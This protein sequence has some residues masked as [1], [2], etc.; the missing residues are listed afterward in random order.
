MSSGN[1]LKIAVRDLE[2]KDPYVREKAV[3]FLIRNPSVEIAEDLIQLLENGDVA[4]RMA[5]L[6]VIKKTGIIFKEKILDL[7]SNPSEDVRVYA[8]EIVSELKIK[9]AIPYLLRVLE[10]DTETVKILAIMALGELRDESVVDALISKLREKEWISFSAITSLAKIK[11]KRSI[12]PLIDVLEMGDDFLSVCALKSLLEFDEQDVTRPIF[13]TISKIEGPRRKTFLKVILEKGDGKL[14]RESYERYG[15]LIVPVLEE[16]ILEEKRRDRRILEGLKFVKERET[17][18]IL[19]EVLDEI[20]EESE[21]YEYVSSILGQIKDL[22]IEDL[23]FYEEKDNTRLKHFIAAAK[24]AGTK[25]DDKILVKEFMRGSLDVR[26]FIVKNLDSL[27]HDGREIASLSFRDLD[28]HIRGYACQFVGR[29]E[30]KE[31]EPELLRIIKDDFP[32]VRVKALEALLTVNRERAKFE[33]E[34]LVE[35]EGPLGLKI[36]LQVSSLLTAEEN[37]PYVLKILSMPDGKRIALKVIG[38]FVGE[39]KF[40]RL[41]EEIM[42]DEDVPHE[43]LKIIKEKRLKGFEDKLVKIFERSDDL[44]KR[45]FALGALSTVED[46]HLS[47]IFERALKDPN[48]LIRVAAVRGLYSVR[49]DEAIPVIEPL[50]SDP[51]ETVRME[52]RYVIE[53]T[54][55]YGS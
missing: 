50:L 14:V 34:K 6:E 40:R 41:L 29:K 1:E 15:K 35:K 37:Y 27:S 7:F 18:R 43:A 21:E 31:F 52:V 17:V 53:R 26:R 16:I 30:L 13:D 5:S 42:E 25:L 12:G 3:D 54:M 4:V 46:P 49:G 44:W 48:S 39:H 45:Y 36:Y 19:L 8:C 55:G 32:D 9:E 22:W 33:I 20:D 10:E 28:G 47:D 2:S 51:E 24:S 38:E 23:A 11:S